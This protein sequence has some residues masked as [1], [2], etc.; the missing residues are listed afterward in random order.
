MKSRVSI[1]AF[2]K[3]TLTED[4]ISEEDYDDDEFD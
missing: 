1:D 2:K 3:Q 4:K